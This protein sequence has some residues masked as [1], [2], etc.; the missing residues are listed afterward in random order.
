MKYTFGTW[1]VSVDVTNTSSLT[2]IKQVHGGNVVLAHEIKNSKPEADGIFLSRKT[3]TAAIYTADC[4]PLIL[5]ASDKALAV[6]VSRKTLIRGLLENVKNF[7]YPTKIMHIFIGPHIC[8]KHFIFEYAGSE[9]MEFKIK[10]PEAVEERDN[11]I[12]LSLQKALKTFLT[13]WGI[14]D[15]QIT[16]DE[17][18]TYETKE[19]PSYKRWIENGKAGNSGHLTTSV[20]TK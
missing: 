11:T 15:D 1:S 2:L 3:D 16:K 4:L 17:R 7:I 14:T 20:S 9:I 18:C 5:M 6:H 13:T 19:L 8:Q 12:S 10:F